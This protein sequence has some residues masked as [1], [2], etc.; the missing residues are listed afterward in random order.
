MNKVG[1]L[2]FIYPTTTVIIIINAIPRAPL[3]RALAYNQILS[4]FNILVCTL[5]THSIER[6]KMIS[7]C[8][9]YYVCVY[10]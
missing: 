3:Q 6:G 5:H 8:C 1:V 2:R 10:V 7:W 4:S 9:Y